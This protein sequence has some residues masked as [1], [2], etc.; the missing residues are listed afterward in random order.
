MEWLSSWRLTSPSI[1]AF[2]ESLSLITS[3]IPKIRQQACC[4]LPKYIVV[5]PIGLY[6]TLSILY[7]VASIIDIQFTVYVGALDYRLTFPK[8]KLNKTMSCCRNVGG[9]QQCWPTGTKGCYSKLLT[10]PV[11]VKAPYIVVILPIVCRKFYLLIYFSSKRVFQW[12][13]P[14]IGLQEPSLF[15]I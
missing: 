3:V 11:L 5:P 8:N 7:S 6:F 15:F 13:R 10:K 12:S 9:Q 14:L 4:L 2:R 1:Q